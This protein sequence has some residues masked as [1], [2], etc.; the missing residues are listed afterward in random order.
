MSATIVA[1]GSKVVHRV[2]V[3]EARLWRFRLAVTITFGL[4]ERRQ[5]FVVRQCPLV[6]RSAGSTTL[7]WRAGSGTP[8]T[9][10]FGSIAPNG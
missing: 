4:W 6:W 5:P 7:V 10:T 2:G 3:I 9:S 1:A 8:T